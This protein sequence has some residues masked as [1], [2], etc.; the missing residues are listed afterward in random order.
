MEYP[1]ALNAWVN[2][3]TIKKSNKTKDRIKRKKKS[4]HAQENIIWQHKY[5]EKII[6]KYDIDRK[7]YV[8]MH[9]III[10]R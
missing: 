7:L 1:T 2:N 5:E 10:K 4:T 9:K 3:R 8:I 6:R